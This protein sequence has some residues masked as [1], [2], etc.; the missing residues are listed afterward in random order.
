MAHTPLPPVHTI[1]AIL[2]AFGQVGH[3]LSSADLEL[4]HIRGPVS[5]RPATR[6]AP[7]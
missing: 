7:R 5:N 2:E 3:G 6:R 1:R 4:G